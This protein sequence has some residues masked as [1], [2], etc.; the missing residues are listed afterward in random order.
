[1]FFGQFRRQS[2]FVDRRSSLRGPRVENWKIVKN[3]VKLKKWPNPYACQQKMDVQHANAQKNVTA[4]KLQK[5]PNCCTCRQKWTR[6][7]TNVHK[8]NTRKVAK[9]SYWCTK[10][11]IQGTKKRQLLNFDPKPPTVI[12]VQISADCQNGYGTIFSPP[13]RSGLCRICFYFCL[14]VVF[15]SFF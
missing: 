15:F 2:N 11:A 5:W 7:A 8:N 3:D 6:Q 10:V 13:G 4:G 14:F 9:P 12:L 1:M